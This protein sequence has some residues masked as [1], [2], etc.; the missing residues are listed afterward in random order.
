MGEFFGNVRKYPKWC[1]QSFL[2]G[3][4]PVLAGVEVKVFSGG[5]GISL[6]W[7]SVGVGA[8]CFVCIDAPPIVGATATRGFSVALGL[9][10]VLGTS[11]LAGSGCGWRCFGTIIEGCCSSISMLVSK[12]FFFFSAEGLS[13]MRSAMK[14]MN[15]LATATVKIMFIVV[16]SKETMT[17]HVI[18]DSSA[19]AY[20]LDEIYVISSNL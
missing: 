12:S 11:I 19:R 6:P 10:A 9:S 7:L 3:A 4:N 1:R 14:K 13:F 5:L 16:G 17:F 20:R 15:R 18:K 2:V 8:S